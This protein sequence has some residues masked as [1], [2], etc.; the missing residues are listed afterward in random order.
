M[1]DISVRIFVHL[2]LRLEHG[3]AVVLQAQHHAARAVRV[4][5]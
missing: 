2:A 5:A 3:D 4:A 1:T